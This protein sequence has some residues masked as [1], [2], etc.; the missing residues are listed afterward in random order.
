M[1]AQVSA[2]IDHVVS[3]LES[4]VKKGAHTA[5][6]IQGLHLQ[7]AAALTPLAV[8]AMNASQQAPAAAAADPTAATAT[9]AP[10]NAQTAP[11]GPRPGTAALLAKGVRE[12]SILV[13]QFYKM[14]GNMIMLNTVQPQLETM[15]KSI[16][17][18]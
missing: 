14:N 16:A 10:E 18:L 12:L 5:D 2:A 3:I 15:R 8:A 13:E 6:E 9:A 17:H 4:A 1:S 7:I 11:P